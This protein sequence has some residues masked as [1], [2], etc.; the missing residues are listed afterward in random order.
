LPDVKEESKQQGDFKVR[1]SASASHLVGQILVEQ[2]NGCFTKHLEV[3]AIQII[4]ARR[5]VRC[6]DLLLG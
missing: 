5:H 3:N 6:R 4:T 1:M 2:R